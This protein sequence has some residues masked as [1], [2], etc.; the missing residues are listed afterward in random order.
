VP[1]AHA[2]PL[3]SL[4]RL[5]LLYA[6]IGNLTFGGGDPTMAALQSE[7]VSSKGWLSAEK[8]GLVYGLARITP[9]TNILA[10]CA[11]TGWELRG[12][13]GAI[14]AVFGA[15][16]PSAAVVV[17]LTA[18]YESV[19]HN[20]RAMAAIAET[21]AAAVGMMAVSAWQLVRPQLRRRSTLRA[22]V[23]VTASVLLSAGLRMSPIT[24]LGLAALAGYFWRLPE[25]A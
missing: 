24:V 20:T 12:W 5:L 2:M 4:R 22:I 21:L 25:Q 16:I 18:G 3:P 19:K 11:G 9:G 10:F 8:Y 6:R 14:L 7:L 15:T 23:L 1:V 17:L 13:L